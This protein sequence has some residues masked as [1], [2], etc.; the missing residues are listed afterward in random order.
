MGPRQ[1]GRL[2]E[3]GLLVTRRCARGRGRETLPTVMRE[4]ITDPLG[5]PDTTL[6]PNQEQCGRL[7]TGSGLGG[8]IKCLNTEATQGN[9]GVYSTGDDMARWLRHNLD[10][11]NPVAWPVLAVAHAVYRQRQS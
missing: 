9:G 10:T 3:R 5:M 8:P 6:D 2:Q 1:Y 11:A 7:M 4:L